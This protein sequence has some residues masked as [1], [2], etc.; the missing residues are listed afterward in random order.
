MRWAQKGVACDA[1]RAAR[2]RASLDIKSSL[3]RNVAM[4]DWHVDDRI[5]VHSIL[6]CI[7]PWRYISVY[8]MILAR[9]KARLPNEQLSLFTP[10]RRGNNISGGLPVEN[11][12]SA[13]CVVVQIP[14]IGS[15]GSNG[16]AVA[17]AVTLRP[18]LNS[19]TVH[20]H[21]LRAADPLV[22]SARL[23]MDDPCETANVPRTEPLR[24]LH[25]LCLPWV[26]S[27]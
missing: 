15:H 2:N 26:I 3:G 18:R 4:L 24:Q 17:H 6:V 7:S 25:N 27:E 23:C 20:A 19:P 10:S 13:F 22:S 8:W 14:S 16:A 9:V 12:L 5:L 21:F 1:H 11:E